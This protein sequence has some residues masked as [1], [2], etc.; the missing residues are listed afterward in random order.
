M[1]RAEVAP[2]LLAAALVG[3]SGAGMEESLPPV[4]APAPVTAP[5]VVGPDPDEVVEVEAPPF[6]LPEAVEVAVRVS[7]ARV[8]TLVSMSPR[9]VNPLSIDPFDSVASCSVVEG[10]GGRPFEVVVADR[11]SDS[12]VRI[13]AV[14]SEVLEAD[15]PS[16]EVDVEVRLLGGPVRLGSARVTFARVDG[17]VDQRTGTVVG[18]TDAG[19]SLSAGFTC[20]GE[21]VAEGA[22][23]RV[24]YSVRL[25]DGLR[26]RSASMT[27][28]DEGVMRCADPVDADRIVV[29]V[30][31]DG[32]VPGGGGGS[33]TVSSRPGLA[34][35][36]SAPADVVLVV[37]G[38]TLILRD[39]TVTLSGSGTGIFSGTSSD[40]IVVDG[41]W[42][43]AG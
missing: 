27:V 30:P 34:S 24:G 43:C 28:V 36:A 42:R 9:S 10:S 15:A 41:A 39:A 40:G 17:S 18:S 21:R 6:G 19:Q 12:S 5:V 2:W 4:T 11:E 22:S 31:A 16:V 3:C 32:G 35:G 29:S 20:S 7:P 26:E 1:F 38:R 14:G 33:L 37:L 25:R 13:T 8:T 23:S